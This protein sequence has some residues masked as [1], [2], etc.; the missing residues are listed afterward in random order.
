[1]SSI[2]KRS[3]KRKKIRKEFIIVNRKDFQNTFAMLSHA[4]QAMGE[5]FEMFR[6][7]KDMPKDMRSALMHVV[8]AHIQNVSHVSAALQMSIYD[9]IDPDGTKGR[10]LN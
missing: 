6:S 9:P 3:T 10:D 8:S 4:L 1:M 7:D 2:S 5:E